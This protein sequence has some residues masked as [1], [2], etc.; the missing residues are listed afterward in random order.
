MDQFVTDPTERTPIALAR[1]SLR[2]AVRSARLYGPFSLTNG[3]LSPPGDP[4]RLT[5]F[6]TILN[7]DLSESYGCLESRWAEY[8]AAFPDLTSDSQVRQMVATIRLSGVEA[9]TPMPGVLSRS[10]SKSPSEPIAPSSPPA[11]GEPVSPPPEIV[12]PFDHGIELKPDVAENLGF[13]N[14]VQLGKGGFGSVYLA[15][16]PALGSRRVAIKYTVLPSRESQVLAA[17][18][19]P[20]I[21]PVLS[22]HE[23]QGARVFCMP[24]HGKHTLADVLQQI[25][26]TKSLPATGV[27]FLS[28]MSPPPEAAP[29]PLAVVPKAELIEADSAEADDQWGY[30]ETDRQRLTRLSYV[31][32]VVLGMTRLADALVHAHC[33]RV[34]HLDIK[35]A[36]ILITDDGV[37]MILDFGL[38]HHD[39]VGPSCT[40]GGTMR[41]MAPEQLSQ[42]VSG[43]VK[44]DVRM[45]LYSLGVVFYELLTGRHPFAA[46]MGPDVPMS[47]RIAARRQMPP[48]VR[49][50]NPS[51]SPAL[52][53][54]VLHLLHPDRMKRYQSAV[55][56]LEDLT[57]HQQHLPLKHAANPSVWERVMKV[58]RRHPVRVVVTG[59]ILIALSATTAIIYHYFQAIAHQRNLEIAVATAKTER[60]VA[61]QVGIRIDAGSIERRAT[62]A[63][64][65]AG[66][67]KWWAEYGLETDPLWRTRPDF[68]QLNDDQRLSVVQSLAEQGLLAAHAERMNA[69]GQPDDVANPALDRAELWN[70][71][72]E[73]LLVGYAL[74]PVLLEQR[75][76]L[77]RLRKRPETGA[78]T[79]TEVAEETNLDLYLRGLARIA[80]R[81]YQDAAE[82]LKRLVTKEPHH[83][84]GQFA[85]GVVYQTTGRYV[86]AIEQYQVAKALAK[87]DPRPAYNR[88]ALLSFYNT[89][90]EALDDLN[91]AL[92]RDSTL[93]E[94]YYQRAMV[95]Y[96]LGSSKPEEFGL[97]LADVNQAIDR[98]GV[99]Y[100]YL[101]LRQT[102]LTQ[103]GAADEAAADLQAMDVIPFHDELD[104]LE[105][106]NR[107]LRPIKSNHPQRVDLVAKRFVGPYGYVLADEYRKNC[108]TTARLDYQA[109]VKRN[110]L[111]S[112]GWKWLAAVESDLKLTEDAIESLKVVIQLLPGDSQ[113]KFNRA[114][115]LARLG[116]RDQAVKQ[117]DGV[118][119]DT[120]GFKWYQKACVYAHS[121]DTNFEDAKVAIEALR[122]AINYG[123]NDYELMRQD[124]DLMKLRNQPGVEELF[125]GPQ[126]GAQ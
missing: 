63:S 78:L 5:D 118:A 95:H 17:L 12:D 38:A 87:T 45:D 36:N 86:E 79:A 107:T 58:R 29:A 81:R 124:P 71:R 75:A 110:P 121:S 101:S 21:V 56:L 16:Q 116:R 33:R 25:D 9:M 32:S 68:A 96:K 88:G 57:R 59:M 43:S 66:V 102:I 4:Q 14:L 103:L 120:A 10:P 41:Y 44:P 123:F 65:I 40:T 105:R 31:D 77:A 106:A 98:G 50:F 62:R 85:L 69:D 24:F 91:T 8:L 54:I 47:Q 6:L 125:K 99:S 37:F 108:M 111:C 89:L 76:E 83:A 27:G 23:Y 73:A 126:K 51:V 13:T 11:S 113:H 117:I 35:P 74:P 39:G 119:A 70:R 64:A 22:V 67:E 3:F 82:G 53:A 100:R 7:A 18:H 90:P 28:T 115:L 46:S 72:T 80:E 52:E 49:A 122:N 97:A 104:Y 93:V 15:Q 34:I 55:Y 60:L 19:H 42:F 112:S 109:A 30:Y 26:Q 48:S 94:A 114:V 84:A 1:F 61:E 20:N 92:E 2:E